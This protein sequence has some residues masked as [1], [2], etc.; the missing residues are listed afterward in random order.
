[1][2]VLVL[3]L[4][5][6][7]VVLVDVDVEVAYVASSRPSIEYPRDFAIPPSLYVGSILTPFLISDF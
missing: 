2:D 1:M 6:L 5:V 7:L 4:L 3:L